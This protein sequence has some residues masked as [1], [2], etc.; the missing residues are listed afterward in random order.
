MS[1]TLL[2]PAAQATLAHWHHAFV[3]TRDSAALASILADDV[4]FRSPFVF[5]PYRG[6]A[7]TMHILSTVI[8]VFEDFR[9]H[10]TFTN[11]TGCVLEFSAR[12]GD[13]ELFGVD[14][15]EFDTNGLMV[16][17]AV[18]IRPGSGLEAVARE[19]G[20]RLGETKAG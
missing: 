15:I 16:D 17:F 9:Y 12:V 19:M 11:E 6:K 14:L 5:K 20:R 13:R 3:E 18:M 10:R 4:T 2:S 1:A 8:N 7:A